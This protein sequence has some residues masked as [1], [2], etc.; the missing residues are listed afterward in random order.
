VLNLGSEFQALR[1]IKGHF[2]GG[3]AFV[4]DVD[5]F[6]GK[7]HKTLDALLKAL[8]APNTP[9]PSIVTALGVP[10]EVAAADGS[11]SNMP[12][13]ALSGAPL[14]GS[15]SQ[16]DDAKP[17]YAIYYWRQRHDYVW[18]LFGTGGLVQKS[19]WYN[20]GE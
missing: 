17:F 10:D 5:G 13:P 15:V 16:L 11:I 9:L 12:G 19:G 6:N 7:K 1:S 20:A 3:E 4:P 8:G 18:F 14:T 2:S